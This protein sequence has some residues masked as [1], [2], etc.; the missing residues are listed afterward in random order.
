MGDLRPSRAALAAPPRAA[1][2]RLPGLVGPAARR[3]RNA[4]A[5]SP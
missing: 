5:A 3:R 2:D 1:G 4:S